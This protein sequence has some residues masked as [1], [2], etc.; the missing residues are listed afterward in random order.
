VQL[1]ENVTFAEA[2]EM[3]A[4]R[5]NIPLE[6]EKSAGR[7]P[8]QHAR[9]TLFD[10]H[11]IACDFFV[12]NFHANGAAGES[13]RRYWTENRKFSMEIAADN[14]IGFG[15]ENGRMLIKR[16]VDGGFSADAMGASG[17]FYCRDGENNPYNY[18]VR[19][20]G[21]LTIPIRDIQGR[22]VGFSARF[23]DG[24]SRPGGFQ[25]AKY[26][27]SPETEIFHKGS[28]LFGLH[29]A[30]QYLGA[31]G[32]FWMVEGQ[33]DV[34]RCRCNGI[35][36]A[37]APQGTAITE[38]QLGTLRRYT[39]RL[40]CMLDGDSAGL[41]A[42]ERML[43]MAIGAG[44]DVKIF[45]LPSGQD[46]DSYFAEDFE[47]RFKSL[48]KSGMSAVEF[49]SFRFLDGNKSMA[50]QEKVDALGK[51]YEVIS[52]AESSIARESHLDELSRVANLDRY[53]LSRDFDSFLTKRKFGGG[54]PIAVRTENGHSTGK[55]SSAEGQLLALVL[56]DD[57]VGRR[58]AELVEQ[59][60]LQN[61]SSDEGKVLLKVLNEIKEC[62]WEGIPTL[63]E[64]QLFS[65]HEKNLMYALLADSV[66]ECERY[67]VAHACL[68]RLYS[69]FVRDQIDDVN[70][71]FRKISVDERD[72]ITDL[73]K[74]RL[75]LR[76]ML[77]CLPNF[78]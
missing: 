15:G 41:K 1:K 58:V 68:R 53:A 59:P 52:M 2:T 25:D 42:V 29:L 63:G 50:A 74:R 76:K 77:K 4:R 37:I 3:I 73:Q 31:N 16:I 23:V 64:M 45:P 46:P 47:N 57:G 13:I 26:I 66:E 55:I 56:A 78:F 30:R 54:A 60:F 12:K 72:A 44:L 21:R 33:F 35:N 14:G 38:A 19:F 71:S 49:L 20:S 65:E 39:T 28:I 67:A 70:R 10:L 17:I 48:Q 43:P 18:N 61:L 32:A 24:V 34:L 5:F 22:I 36:T 75:C 40:N 8:A 9:K 6:F 7:E 51:I 27:N 69:N 62:M 11:E